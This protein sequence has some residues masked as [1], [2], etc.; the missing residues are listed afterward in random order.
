M[1]QRGGTVWANGFAA[2]GEDTPMPVSACM[3]PTALLSA[4]VAMQDAADKLSAAPS[5]RTLNPGDRNVP[6][7][8]AYSN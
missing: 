4:A 8:D 1:R 6:L 5:W 7:L 3:I 2:C